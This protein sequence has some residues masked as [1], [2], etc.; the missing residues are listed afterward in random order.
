MNVL[1][2][3]SVNTDHKAVSWHSIS[4]CEEL[5]GDVTYTYNLNNIRCLFH[6]SDILMN[7]KCSKK[8]FS[9]YSVFF[10]VEIF[11]ID[12]KINISK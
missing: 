10:K 5:C 9:N 4:S 2:N 7:K 11:I 3:T 12:Q 8:N 6:W 1:I